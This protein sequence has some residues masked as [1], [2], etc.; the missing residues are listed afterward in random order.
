MLHKKFTKNCLTSLAVRGDIFAPANMLQILVSNRPCHLIPPTASSTVCRRW[1]VGTALVNIRPTAFITTG[2]PSSNGGTSN[3]L[4]PIRT[5]VKTFD[6]LSISTTSITGLWHNTAS[7][8][9]FHL[10]VLE[11]SM[12]AFSAKPLLQL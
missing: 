3:A 10:P 9:S 12:Q 4:G 2:F 1:Q 11:P 6:Q 8:H 7:F 5:S